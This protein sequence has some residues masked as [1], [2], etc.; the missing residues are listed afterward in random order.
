[1]HSSLQQAL[2]EGIEKFCKI[3]MPALFIML[4]IVIIYVAVQPGAMDGYK[5]MFG[6]NI[7]PLKEDFLKVLKTRQARCSSPCPSAWAL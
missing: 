3:G 6:W 4:L 1:M 5:F 7:E 2:P